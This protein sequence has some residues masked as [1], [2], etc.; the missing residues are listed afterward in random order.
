MISVFAVETAGHEPVQLDPQEHS[1]YAW[2]PYE[3]AL[4]RVHFRGL[5]DGL[6]STREYIID[7]DAPAPELRLR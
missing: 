2:L 3:E 4:G 6:R 5:K 1:E 7:V